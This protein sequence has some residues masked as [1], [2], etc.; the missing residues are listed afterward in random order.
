MEARWVTS[1]SASWAAKTCIHSTQMRRFRKIVGNPEM[2][3]FRRYLSFLIPL[4]IDDDSTWWTDAA[5][6]TNGSMLLADVLE[7]FRV[8]EYPCWCQFTLRWSK[9]ITTESWAVLI[10]TGDNE[11]LTSNA[12][13]DGRLESI[14]RVRWRFY[15]KRGC[16]PEYVCRYLCSQGGVS[17][18][19]YIHFPPRE[20]T[21]ARD[22]QQLTKSDIN[23]GG[24]T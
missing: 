24:E 19:D 17:P 8:D 14:V 7:L 3:Q 6:A 12:R 22:S 11:V 2:F 15:K 16:L 9:A 13:N 18:P 1:P 5:A 20:W 10:L 21:K 4:G 23:I